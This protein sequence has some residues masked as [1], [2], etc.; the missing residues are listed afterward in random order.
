MGNIAD[1]CPRTPWKGGRRD[2]LSKLRPVVRSPV[3]CSLE[4]LGY[5]ED[6]A[7][8]ATSE[9]DIPLSPKS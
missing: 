6:T 2:G 1:H 5:P 4:C 9:T 8:L 3:Y 7:I